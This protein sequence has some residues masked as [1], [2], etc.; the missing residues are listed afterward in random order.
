MGSAQQKMTVSLNRSLFERLQEIAK[1]RRCRVDELIE[2]SVK[3]SYRL[4]DMDER[5]KA[6]DELEQLE[7]P[8]GD[9]EE[10]EEDIIKGATT[11]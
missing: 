8:V 11:S 7:L 5:L 6:V 4:Y 1:R 3:A 10:I 9:W 2:E